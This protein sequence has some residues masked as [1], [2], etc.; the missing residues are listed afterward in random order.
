MFAR[1]A[2]SIPI[3]SAVT[4]GLL[5][6]MQLLIA[7]GQDVITEARAYRVVDLVR[8]DRSDVPETRKAEPKRPPSPAVPPEIPAPELGDSFDTSLSISIGAPVVEA[9]PSAAGIGFGVGDGEYLPIVKVAP[10]YP[11]RALARR[12][13]GH[14]VLEFVVTR[15]GTVK[16]I[17]VLDSTAPIF[18]QPAIEAAE[19]FRYKPRIIDGEPVEVAGVRNVIT[20]KMAG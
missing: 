14:V 15:S 17:V 16:D 13:E 6:A 7:T 4:F 20:F 1:L 8:V 18:E 9:N 3:G 19:R 2:L 5:F 12:L 11:R 10:V